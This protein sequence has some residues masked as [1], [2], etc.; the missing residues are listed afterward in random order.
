MVDSRGDEELRVRARGEWE[1][2]AGAREGGEGDGGGEGV[3]G[4]RG[5]GGG[6]GGRGGVGSG[7]TEGTRARGLGSCPGGRGGGEGV[8]GGAVRGRGGGVKGEGEESVEFDALGMKGVRVGVGVVVAVPVFF[9]S[10]L[11]F[12]AVRGLCA[13]AAVED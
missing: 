9:L 10:V 4:G 11:F 5:G 7:I 2:G 3:S 1:N 13:G 12:A 6:E 8:G